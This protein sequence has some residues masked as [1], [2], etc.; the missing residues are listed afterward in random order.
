VH[1]FVS[2]IKDSETS[3]LGAEVSKSLSESSAG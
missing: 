2:H 3:H 1:L